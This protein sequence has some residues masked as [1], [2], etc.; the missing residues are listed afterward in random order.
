MNTNN[1]ISNNIL[2]SIS[3]IYDLFNTSNLMTN[4][5]IQYIDNFHNNNN[6]TQHIYIN[7]ALNSL[8]YYKK[9][10]STEI[11]SNE[12]AI[13]CHK[14]SRSEICKNKNNNNNN[15]DILDYAISNLQNFI[16]NGHKNNN[17][18]KKIKDII[19][20]YKKDV[21]HLFDNMILSEEQ[22]NII[23]DNIHKNINK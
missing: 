8:K 15:E 14:S 17:N 2:S 6:N 3:K 1:N 11:T 9:I 10:K 5:I 22:K 18:L 21:N 23:I 16:D 7:N 20:N 4:K 12:N 13:S 19:T